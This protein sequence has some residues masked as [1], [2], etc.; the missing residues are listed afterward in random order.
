MQTLSPN[1]IK[2]C[3]REDDTKERPNEDNSKL[4]VDQENNK[5]KTSGSDKKPSESQNSE[6][7]EAKTALFPSGDNSINRG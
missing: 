2:P 7:S 5:T 4:P 3:Y 6:G 1:Y